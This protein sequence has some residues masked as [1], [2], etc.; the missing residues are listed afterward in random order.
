MILSFSE[1]RPDVSDYQ[2][3]YSANVINVVPR[4]DGYGPFFNSVP[5]S[6]ALPAACRGFFYARKSDGTISVFAGTASKLYNLNNTTAA[7]TDVSLGG[8]GYTGPSSNA[9]WCFAQFNNFVFATQKNDPIQ[10]FDLT[11][12]SAFANLAGSPPQADTIAVVNRFLVVSGIQSPNVY[13]IQW[14]GLNATT[15]WTS[16]VNQ[17]DFQDLADGG[18]VRGVAGGE[19]GTIFQDS[20]IRRLT[21]S[22]GSPYVFGITRIAQDDGLMAPYS[23]ISASDRILWL[24]PQG[25]KMLT[26]GGYPTPIGREKVD[27]TFFASWDS[28]NP[29]LMIGSADPR[30]GRAYWA[31]KSN[32]GASGLFDRILVYDWALDRWSSIQ[33]SGEYLSSL[34]QP[35]LTLE[36]IDTVYGSNIDTIN[37][38]SFDAVSNAAY[39]QVSGVNA[40]HQLGFLTGGALEATMDTPEQGGDGRRIRVRGFRPVSD[41]PVVFG[42]IST[43]D[44]AH[45]TP[46]Y[47][48]EVAVNAI[49]VCPFNA[50]TRYARGRIRIPAGTS[51][52]FAAGVEPDVVPSGKI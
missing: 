33:M 8:G 32:N 20:A 3:Q 48:A 17:S 28:N 37:L 12:S 26:P 44:T 41:A 52:N 9:N 43:R 29:Q 49:G 14:S 15:T 34:A 4:A 40:A 39:S 23:L 2:G 38:S 50:E 47:G 22:P 42:S 5:Y 51:W 25:F 31:Y 11:S 45:A 36:Q 13:R 16:G 7:W 10:V 30:I 24:S 46:S 6:Q 19:F 1:Y 18:L 21:Y 35:G 27:R